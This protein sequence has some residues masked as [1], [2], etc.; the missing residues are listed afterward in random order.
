MTRQLLN[1]ERTKGPLKLKHVGHGETILARTANNFVR[2]RRGDLSWLRA[3]IEALEMELREA[4]PKTQPPLSDEEKAATM[5]ALL[6]T[7]EERA[8]DQPIA[9]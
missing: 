1:F 7:L 8:C 3:A 4:Q 6:S 9:R 2:L 5:N